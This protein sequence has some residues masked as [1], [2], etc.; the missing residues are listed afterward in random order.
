M[1][2][3]DF[4]DVLVQNTVPRR[5]TDDAIID[6]HDGCL[7]FF[8]GRYYLYGTAYGRSAGFGLNNRYRVYSSPDLGEWRYE[9]ELLADQPAGVFYRPYVVF[10]PQTR[11]YVLWF[12]WYPQLWD[13]ATGVA[14]SETPV[15]P[16]RIVASR[17]GLS[18]AAD[19]PGDGSL[20]VDD[21]GT[22]YYIHTIIGQGHAIRI[23]KLTADF[24]GST[25]EVSEVLARG[26]EAPALFRRGDLYYALFDTACCFCPQGSGARVYTA[27]QPLGPYTF[28]GNLNRDA[29]D[30]PIIAAQQT[31]VARLPGPQGDVYLWMGDRWGSRPD[32]IKGHDFQYWSAP[33]AFA[34]EGKIQPL[35]FTAEWRTALRRGQPPVTPP[36]R[37]TQ[38]KRPDPN[39]VT[40]DPCTRQPI[41]VENQD[42]GW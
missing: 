21:D 42:R 1:H 10:N 32:G 19:R 13:G 37:Y 2:P 17:V 5:D 4:Q 34:A 16:F 3:T 40:T 8:A 26:C 35:T 31:Y 20:F 41:P 14:V 6:A 11:L 29:Q 22:G 7:Q 12:N 27:R 38:P 36:H 33:L 24:L 15:G 28:Q 23:E 30:R 39:P 18:Q 9:G 25:G